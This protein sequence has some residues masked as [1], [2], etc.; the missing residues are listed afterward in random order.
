[1]S[2][3]SI[4]QS[5]AR[6]QKEMDI[7]TF[8]GKYMLNVPGPGIDSGF[9]MDPFMRLQGW[10]AN[11]RTNT[12][13][14]ESDLRGMTRRTNKDCV[15]VNNYK[16]HAALTSKQYYGSCRPYTEQSRAITPAWEVRETEQSHWMYLPLNPQEH[17]CMPFHNNICSRILE[18]DYYRPT[19]PQMPKGEPNALPADNY[20]R[21]KGPNAT[22]FETNSC[23]YI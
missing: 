6:V 9:Q 21:T 4:K 1:M 5:P 20:L 13:N 15:G 16:K 7:S 10:G 18:K 19:V 12:T 17:V 3:T 14:L 23:R 11:L 8:T 2:L 22:C